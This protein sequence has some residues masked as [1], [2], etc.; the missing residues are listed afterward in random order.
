MKPVQWLWLPR[1]RV[2]VLGSM[3]SC[4]SLINLCKD[5]TGTKTQ[6]K[7]PSGVVVGSVGNVYVADRNNHRIRRSGIFGLIISSHRLF[8][9]HGARVLGFFF[10]IEDINVLRLVLCD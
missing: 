10:L 4:S 3:L 7:S 6:F 9:T 1:W 8:L 2:M 5:D